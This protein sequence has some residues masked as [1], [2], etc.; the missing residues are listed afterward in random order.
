MPKQALFFGRA[1]K[2]LTLG[3]AFL[4]FGPLKGAVC[5]HPGRSVSEQIAGRSIFS[6]SGA[7]SRSFRG[8]YFA[9]FFLRQLADRRF[10]FS[11]SELAFAPSSAR[12]SASG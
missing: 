11:S 3:S 2:W 7:L 1:S 4:R 9:L 10:N 8:V 5:I 6:P 12:A